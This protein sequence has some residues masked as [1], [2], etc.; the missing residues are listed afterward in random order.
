MIFGAMRYTLLCFLS[1]CVFVVS[2]GWGK[3]LREHLKRVRITC[4]VRTPTLTPVFLLDWIV[5]D[6]ETRRKVT[7][8]VL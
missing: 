2:G 4:C 7:R 6:E 1:F 5:E 8:N 3:L